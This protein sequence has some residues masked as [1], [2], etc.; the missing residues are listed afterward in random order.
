TLEDNYEITVV[1][2]KLKVTPVTAEV[3]VTITGKTLT[4]KYDGTEKT[5]TGY[6]VEISNPL[7]KETDIEFSGD[8]TANGTDAGT[9][10]MGLTADDF[11]NTSK[12]FTNVK[13]VVEDGTLTISKRAVT[14]TSGDGEKVYDG[15][16]LTNETVTVGGDGF[17]TGEGATYEVTGT[18]TI[19]GSS[20]NTFTY[21]LNEGTK[22]DNYDITTVPGT[23]TVSGRNYTITYDPNG[24]IWPDGTTTYKQDTYA[25]NEIAIIRNA[26]KRPGYT[27]IRWEGSTYQPGEQYHEKDAN[28]MFVDDTLV[29][30]WSK[31]I[32]PYIAKTGDS[33]TT[34]TWGALS[35]TSFLGALGLFLAKKKRRKE[36]AE[37]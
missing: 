22:A 9:Y 3:T 8:A 37:A 29:A 28:G 18:Q 5:V 1:P 19:P 35:G 10:N 16:A 17:A 11:K 15:T 4:G 36:E 14:L 30:V 7:Y 27:F 24:G 6:D 13:F 23:L 31:N 2:G 25:Y 33:N 12:N 20:E 26:P 21:T 32:N 34:M